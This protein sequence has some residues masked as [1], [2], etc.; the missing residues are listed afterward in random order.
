[1]VPLSL[2]GL[3]NYS[4]Q[5]SIGSCLIDQKLKKIQEKIAESESGKNRIQRRLDEKA[6]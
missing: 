5:K 4:E 3:K 6:I 2:Q 1:M